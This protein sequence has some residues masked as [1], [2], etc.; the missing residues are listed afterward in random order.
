M[1][2]IN[3]NVEKYFEQL[4]TMRA[5]SLLFYNFTRDQIIELKKIREFDHVWSELERKAIKKKWFSIPDT[6]FFNIFC[7]VSYE[8][9]SEIV[10]VAFEKYGDE[11]RKGIKSDQE[12][13]ELFRKQISEKE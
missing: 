12:M 9:Q 6:E 8:T 7:H 3:P 10:R 1:K 4:V 11:A 13:K 2:L 5:L